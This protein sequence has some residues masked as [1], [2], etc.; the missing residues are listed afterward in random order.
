MVNDS[1]KSDERR[2]KVN[3]TTLD[4]ADEGTVEDGEAHDSFTGTRRQQLA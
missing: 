2:K 4:V 1:F 3:M